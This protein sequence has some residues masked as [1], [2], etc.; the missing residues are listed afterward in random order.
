[1]IVDNFIYPNNKGWTIYSKSNCLYCMKVKELL[2]NQKE[3]RIINCDDLINTI[4]TNFLDYDD[5]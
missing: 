1:M 4:E 3:I 2:E 5:W